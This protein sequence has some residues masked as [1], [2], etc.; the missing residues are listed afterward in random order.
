MEHSLNAIELTGTVDEN[1]QLRLD[2][3]LPIPGPRR[4]RVIVLYS[5][6][7]DW[8]EGEW[9]YTAARSPAFDFLRELREDIYTR[10]DG[11]PFDDE[12]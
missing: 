9:L 1:N 2:E 5:E 10:E 12:V 7:R 4:V 3:R 6:D 8:E 11:K